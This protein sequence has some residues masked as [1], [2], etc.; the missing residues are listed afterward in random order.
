MN[1]YI[2]E[3]RSATLTEDHKLHTW[4]YIEKPDGTKE[5]YG[6]GPSEDSF[7]NIVFGPG[8]VKFEDPSK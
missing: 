1:A 7:G 8:K 5:A 3:I 4:V 6:F 2:F